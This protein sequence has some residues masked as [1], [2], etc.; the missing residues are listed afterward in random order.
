[1]Q[2]FCILN[3]LVKI[4][5]HSDGYLVVQVYFVDDR[6]DR[7]YLVYRVDPELDH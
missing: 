2:R 1:M 7:R 6:D 5:F 3:S 4:K